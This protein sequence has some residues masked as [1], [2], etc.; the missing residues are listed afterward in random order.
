[1]KLNDYA[2]ELAYEIYESCYATPKIQVDKQR[3]GHIW[4]EDRQKAY[5]IYAT[6]RKQH[7]PSISKE[8]LDRI[9]IPDW[10]IEVCDHA[11]D[12]QGFCHSC[13]VARHDND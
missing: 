5:E 11:W 2:K 13:G 8:V 3:V 7:V 10:G 12:N 9:P 6:A 4:R 1:M